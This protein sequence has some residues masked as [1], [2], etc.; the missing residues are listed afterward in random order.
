MLSASS[1]QSARLSVSSDGNGRPGYASGGW[2]GDGRV[3]CWKVTDTEGMP[4][5]SATER[6]PAAAGSMPAATSTSDPSAARESR[7]AGSR[8][9]RRRA[10]AATTARRRPRQRARRLPIGTRGTA[11]SASRSANSSSGVR[12]PAPRAQRPQLHRESHQRFDIPARPVGR[13]HRTHDATP[14]SADPGS[15]GGVCGTERRVMSLA[16]ALYT[17]GGEAWPCFSCFEPR[18]EIARDD[19]L[20]MDSGRVRRGQPH[21]RRPHDLQIEQGAT[22]VGTQVSQEPC[23]WRSLRRG[24]GCWP[25][26]GVSSRSAAITRA[27]ASTAAPD[28]P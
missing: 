3:N 6:A 18:A 13:Q 1:S 7:R 12:R 4:S 5:L 28:G 15:G 16:R 20:V 21:D 17:G 10:R 26:T 19:A 2:Y 23:R 27:R 8:S 9:A 14:M 24:A 25:S 11:I 22:R